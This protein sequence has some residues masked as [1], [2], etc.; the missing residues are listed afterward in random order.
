MMADVATKRRIAAERRRAL[1][2]LNKQYRTELEAKGY[3]VPPE[4]P[5]SKRIPRSPRPRHRAKV[6]PFNPGQRK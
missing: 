4:K 1:K 5:P 3:Y 6:L 2:G